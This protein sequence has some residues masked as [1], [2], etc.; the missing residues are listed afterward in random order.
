MRPH[1]FDGERYHL[2][3]WVIMPRHVHGHRDTV[4]AGLIARWTREWPWTPGRLPARIRSRLGRDPTRERGRLARIRL[5]TRKCPWTSAHPQQNACERDPPG[6]AGVSPAYDLAVAW[7]SAQVACANKACGETPPG[8]AG[9]SPAY[10]LAIWQRTLQRW[11]RH[12]TLQGN[13]AESQAVRK[14]KDAGE[15]PALP[16]GLRAGRPRSRVGEHPLHPSAPLTPLPVNPQ[17]TRQTPN[18]NPVSTRGCGD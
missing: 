5:G 12:T 16:G 2:L 18:P 1:T 8:S 15:T 17:G 14:N 9:V 11:D 4:P 13:G 10:G 6:S 7:T 3:A